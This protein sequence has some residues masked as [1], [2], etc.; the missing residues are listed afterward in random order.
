MN[1][2]SKNIKNMTTC[3]SWNSV[4]SPL[5]TEMLCLFSS[6]VPWPFSF[7]GI[8]KLAEVHHI[9]L[10]HW[11]LHDN[12]LGELNR[13]TSWPSKRLFSRVVKYEEREVEDLSSTA[14]TAIYSKHGNR[15]DNKKFIAFSIIGVREWSWLNLKYIYI[16]I[17]FSCYITSHEVCDNCTA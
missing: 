9:F 5:T 4:F 8:L 14:Q 2:T 3:W 13:L 15:I 6:Q 17:Y 1:F 10:A 16:Y 7:N 12:R 11:W